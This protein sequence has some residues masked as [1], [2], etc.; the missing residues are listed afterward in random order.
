MEAVLGSEVA[1][2]TG[3][4]VGA[5]FAGSHGLAEGGGEHERGALPGGRRAG[6]D[7]PRD[8]PLVLT[9]IDSVWAVHDAQRDDDDD[10]TAARRTRDPRAS[11]V[12]RQRRRAREVTLALVAMRA[13]LAAASLPRAINADNRAAAASPAYETARL[14]TVFGVGID[15]VRAF[16]LLLIAASAVDALRRA[17]A[18]ARRAPLR[19]R[20]PARAR[21]RRGQ[22][23][24]GAGRREPSLLAVAGARPR[25]WRSPTRRG[26]RRRAGAGGRA[27][28]GRRLDV[29]AARS[30]VSRRSRSPRVYWRRCG[31]RGAPTASTSRPRLPNG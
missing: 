5:T 7:R 8:R 29:P 20:D 21:A 12:V 27:A 16:A 3:L 25:A 9:G 13:P 30:G 2:A 22:V 10:D 24:V 31:P 6:A 15:V 14:L 18:G 19:P 4:G 23:V 11:G 17:R 28:R 26:D 1:R